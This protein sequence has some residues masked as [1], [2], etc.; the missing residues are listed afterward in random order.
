MEALTGISIDG[1]AF[2]F[3]LV[4]GAVL[5]VRGSISVLRHRAFRMDSLAV[6]LSGVVLLGIALITLGDS[7]PGIV[8]EIVERTWAVAVLLGVALLA[9]SLVEFILGQVRHASTKVL[10]GAHLADGPAGT[11]ALGASLVLLIGVVTVSLTVAGHSDG[12]AE[13]AVTQIELHGGTR[14]IASYEMPGSVMDIAMLDDDVGYISIAEGEILRFEI[15]GVSNDGIDVTLVARI[16]GQPRGLAILN[17]HLYVTE[18]DNL[19]CE[20][21]ERICVGSTINANPRD[22]ELEILGTATGRVMAFDIQPDGTLGE[23]SVLLDNLPVVNSLHA[24]NGIASGPSGFL[25][26]SIGG[27]DSLWKTPMAIE[28]LN[29]PHLDL[30]GTVLRVDP[31]GGDVAV[32]ARGL[33]NVYGLEFDDRGELYGVDN[34]GPTLGG[35]RREAVIQIEQDDD[36]GYPWKG[37]SG[38]AGATYAPLWFLDEKGSAG[39]SPRSDLGLSSGLLI[40]TCGSLWSMRF[41]VHGPVPIIRRPPETLLELIPGC[42]TSIAPGPGQTALVGLFAG[43]DEPFPLLLIDLSDVR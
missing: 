19:P 43:G 41:G 28:G 2:L 29:A 7:L 39:L 24:V 16:Q 6:L 20:P 38:V 26:V 10:R 15:S 42:V 4:V 25:Y 21:E 5:V 1:W 17:H 35:W 18:V 23:P 12:S 14:L 9:V 33:R 22:G 32:F 3:A 27:L 8:S 31:D 36:F 37:S 11:V 30:L 13:P 34:D 40:G